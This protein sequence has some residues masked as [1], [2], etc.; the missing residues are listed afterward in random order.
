MA[1]PGINCD[2]LREENPQWTQRGYATTECWEC[3]YAN[4]DGSVNENG[5]VDPRT[6]IDDP[7]LPAKGAPHPIF[8]SALV[9]D[10]RV[11]QVVANWSVIVVVTYRGWGLYHGGPRGLISAYGQEEELELPVWR[12]LQQSDA[13]TGTSLTFY[14]LASPPVMWRRVTVYR[15]ETKFIPGQNVSAI[16]NTICANAGAWYVFDGQ[17]F[18]LSGRSGATYD[19]TGFTA[20]NYRFYTLGPVPAMAAG[21]VLGNDVAIP[22]LPALYTYSSRLDPNNRSAPPIITAV[23]LQITAPQGQPLPGF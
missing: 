1:T 5:L 19:G 18:L 9:I 3:W 20:V 6:V 22:A 14:T 13:T 21:S 16:Q 23:P 4:S 2:R 11:S 17:Y 10:K 8:P 7:G 12:R 15:C